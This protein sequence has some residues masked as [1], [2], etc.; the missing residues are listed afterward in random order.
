MA[1]IMPFA[2]M[3]VCSAFVVAFL[4]G[5]MWL[6]ASLIVGALATAPAYVVGLAIH[7]Y[8]TRRS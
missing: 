4:G 3:F 8:L 5:P 1:V 6:I 2:L 7:T